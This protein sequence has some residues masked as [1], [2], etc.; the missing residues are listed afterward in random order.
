M[1]SPVEEPPT[2]AVFS[3][4][5]LLPPLLAPLVTTGAPLRTSLVTPGATL[6]TALHANC[7]RLRI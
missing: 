3:T 5:K 2:G 4:R 1:Q 6:V 7:L